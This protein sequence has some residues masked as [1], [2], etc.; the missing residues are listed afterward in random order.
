MSSPQTGSV[1]AR[2]GVGGTENIGMQRSHE[3]NTIFQKLLITII[4]IVPMLHFLN[5]E[6]QSLRDLTR[7]WDAPGWHTTQGVIEGGYVE[8]QKDDSRYYDTP[9]VTYL[10]AVDG[11]AYRGSSSYL[12]DDGWAGFASYRSRTEAQ[13]SLADRP[14][15]KRVTV[16]YDPDRPQDAVLDRDKRKSVLTARLYL[17]LGFPLCFGAFVY[18]LT[19]AGWPARANLVIVVATVA[20]WALLLPGYDGN[21]DPIEG[22]ANVVTNFKA[23]P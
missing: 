8:T 19:S 17:V 13:A 11:Q 22:G 9:Y 21:S 6:A 10:Y 4:S 15:G 18:L 12:Y 23:A 1:L 3:E 14:A 20:V 16:F 2:S 7:T 5:L